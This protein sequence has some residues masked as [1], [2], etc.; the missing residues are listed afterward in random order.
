MTLKQYF[1]ALGIGVFLALLSLIVI[2]FNVNP[3]NNPVWGPILFYVSF[4]FM[5]CGLYAIGG[6]LW[7]VHVL[8]QTDIVFRQ[9]KKT[10]RQGCLFGGVAVLALILQH[11]NLLRWWSI[12]LLVLFS[13]W[14][15]S[16]FFKKEKK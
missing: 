15:E 2:I 1:I 4:F 13:L 14:V 7:R 5:V 6:F 3:Q 8:K 16:I 11:F 12:F 9:I 10:F